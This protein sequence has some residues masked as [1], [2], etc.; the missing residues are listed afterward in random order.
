MYSVYSKY[1]GVCGC[2]STVNDSNYCFPNDLCQ[3]AK[4]TFSALDECTTY[5]ASECE[6]EIISIYA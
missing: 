5:L 2:N 4:Y 6:Y 3:S 1:L